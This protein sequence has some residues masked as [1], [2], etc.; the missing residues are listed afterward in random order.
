M[1]AYDLLLVS[2]QD[3]KTSLQMLV[4]KWFVYAQGLRCTRIGL[5]FLLV[6]F[7]TR[8]CSDKGLALCVNNELT[9]D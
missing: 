8:R 9:R 3:K 1:G 5:L 7:N 4:V 2:F 6:D